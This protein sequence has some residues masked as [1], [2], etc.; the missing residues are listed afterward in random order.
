MWIHVLRCH[1]Q[2]KLLPY[3]SA[4]RTLFLPCSSPRLALLQK[5]PMRIISKSCYD[6]PVFKNLRILPLNDMYLT[7][8]GKVE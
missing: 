2:I 7:E 8:V 3:K 4:S 5:R 6:E 1:F